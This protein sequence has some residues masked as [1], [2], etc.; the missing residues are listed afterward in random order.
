MMAG[1]LIIA[2][3]TVHASKILHKLALSNVFHSP[4]S[5]FDMTP[6]GR[7][8]NRFSKDLDTVDV[9]LPTN[10][11]SWIGCFISVSS[12]YGTVPNTYI[13]K[14]S[15]FGSNKPRKALTH[16]HDWFKSNQQSKVR[17]VQC[18]VLLEI[19]NLQDPKY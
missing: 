6:I 17:F 18:G 13:I 14:S 11:R 19:L 9:M 15:V 12:I 3:A 4:M 10:L 1:S 2:A 8:V 7:I 16:I 5:F